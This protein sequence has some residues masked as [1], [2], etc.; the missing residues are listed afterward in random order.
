LVDIPCIL[1][2]AKESRGQQRSRLRSLA[3][4]EDKVEV[5]GTSEVAFDGQEH[6]TGLASGEDDVHSRVE[7]RKQMNVVDCSTVIPC[8]LSVQ[9]AVFPEKG[10]VRDMDM[11]E[12]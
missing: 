2:N 12:E 11:G 4:P 5:I 8:F 6:G 1:G 7:W 3:L 9:R 10:S